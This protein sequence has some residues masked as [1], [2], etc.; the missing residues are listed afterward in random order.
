MTMNIHP[1]FEILEE[2]GQGESAT[3][4]RARDLSLRRGV[5]IKEL[6]EDLRGEPARLERFIAEARLL[7]GLSHENIVSIYAVDPDRGW[8]V[9]ELM[10]GGLD[11]KLAEGPLK[12]DLVRSVLRQ[13]LEGLK[14]LQG[15]GLIHGDVKPANLLYDEIGRVKLGD[16]AGLGFGGEVRAPD[17]P[18]KAIAPE[19][20]RPEFG[21][22]GP[23]VD[24][25]CLGFAAL[26][27][28]IGPS[29]DELFQDS[30]SEAGGL[31]WMR[32]HADVD[33]AL[34]ATARLITSVPRDLACV[35]DR[36]I[37]KSVIDRYPDP[38][39]AIADLE[40]RP[41]TL[42]DQAGGLDRAIEPTPPARPAS[43][44]PAR[45]RR[46]P[47]AASPAR[48]SREWFNRQLSRPVVLVPVVAGFALVP[49]AALLLPG[50]PR[51]P[52]LGLVRI[53]ADPPNVTILLDG[54]TLNPQSDPT[55]QG[56]TL[57]PGKRR[58]HF[59]ADGYLASDKTVEV[60]AG[61]KVQVI[62]VKLERASALLKVRTL[63]AGAR[64]SIDDRPQVA[65]SEAEFTVLPGRH[66][67]H[68]EAGGYKPSDREVDVVASERTKDVVITLEPLRVE[69]L[70]SAPTALATRRYEGKA[71][72][73]FSVATSA[74]G[75]IILTGGQD[76]K[77]RRLDLTTGESPALPGS[78]LADEKGCSDVYSV[79]VSADGKLALSGGCD[80]RVLV[81][82]LENKQPPRVLL[83]HVKRVWGVAIGPDSTFGLSVG[84]D[85]SIRIWD[86]LEG[87][88]SGQLI[89]HQN[90]VHALAI[91]PDGANALTGDVVG[92]VR[93]WDLASRTMIRELKG[94]E[95]RVKHASISPDG[96]SALTSGKDTTVR[97]WD[98]RTGL[99]RHGFLDHDKWATA[100][101]F[102]PDG[103]RALSCS[104]DQTVV[105]HDLK[106]FATIR[107]FKHHEDDV[108][109]VTFLP[110]SRQAISVGKDGTPALFALDEVSEPT[111]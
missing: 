92:S 7:A 33:A 20:L 85:H 58:F 98:L 106:T 38:A 22:V 27:M 44:A 53:A 81:H 52:E 41:V 101:V 109:N 66:R 10:R 1:N 74:D 25:Y 37:A 80:G 11:C 91:S 26:E 56:L 34:P 93:Y 71:G 12:A 62:E 69:A 36:L 43:P 32:W 5:A 105:L 83:G 16:P 89:G 75:K 21:P 30:G 9:M 111:R 18:P 65:T 6:R 59:E 50:H 2:I 39:S 51:T 96:R 49:I 77:V 108:E 79:A 29:F 42:V 84:A 31:G 23:G 64:I 63:P 78:H 8:I 68:A 48:W 19:L 86:L 24:L 88:E 60:D 100:A 55:G 90:S 95:G 17:G 82:D 13:A 76:G 104:N 28:L 46:A 61:A 99:E 97:L 4:Y 103:A 110:G 14:F 70:N 72:T 15:H 35:I 67:L 47:L 73:I 54:K 3:V 40:S 107:V 57:F 45:T 94:H 102:S 87:R